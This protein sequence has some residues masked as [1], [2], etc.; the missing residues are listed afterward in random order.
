MIDTWRLGLIC[1][2]FLDTF[3]ARLAIL[4]I[5]YLVSATHDSTVVAEKMEQNISKLFFLRFL[6]SRLT[7]DGEDEDVVLPIYAMKVKVHVGV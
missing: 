7:M 5:L 6:T 3:D 4:F 2:V 1:C